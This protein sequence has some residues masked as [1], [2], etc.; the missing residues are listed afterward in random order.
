[1]TAVPWKLFESLSD[2]SNAKNG[3][4]SLATAV[5]MLFL[6]AAL[7]S[8]KAAMEKI[9]NIFDT[10]GFDVMGWREVPTDASVLGELN[11]QFLP[12]ITQG[13][14]SFMYHST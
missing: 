11:K 1:M 13:E 2:I 4:G 10:N 8:R 9:H 5:G 12:Y 6:P 14:L 3:D 7:D